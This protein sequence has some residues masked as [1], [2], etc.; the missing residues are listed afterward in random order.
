LALP[1]SWLRYYSLVPTLVVILST[2]AAMAEADSLIG[3][4]FIRLLIGVL[5]A[6]TL[7]LFAWA[8]ARFHLDEVPILKPAE[9][10][11][12]VVNTQLGLH[13]LPEVR[14]KEFVRAFWAG[15]IVEKSSPW[16]AL[17]NPTGAIEGASLPMLLLTLGLL[18]LTYAVALVAL[19]YFVL[20][21]VGLTFFTVIDRVKQ[22]TGLDAAGRIPVLAILLTICGNVI[23]AMT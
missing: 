21:F 18:L 11:S 14:Q 5:I 10:V 19:C 8:N 4:I 23:D 9:V 15:K 1:L 12:N 7:S 3:A 16:L 13:I 17:Y 6:L 22:F 20:C 2:Y